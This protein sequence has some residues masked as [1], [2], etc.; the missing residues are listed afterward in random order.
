MER[1]C[2]LSELCVGNFGSVVS[3]CA[4][5]TC[6]KR[7]LD[8]GLIRGTRVEAVMTSPSGDPTAYSI[9]GALIALRDKDAEKILVRPM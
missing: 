2:P 7:M 4:G 1:I 9:R 3:M 8:L 6:R 5:G